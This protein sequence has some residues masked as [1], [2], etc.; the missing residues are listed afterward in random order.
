MQGLQIN[1]TVGRRFIIKM[2][3]EHKE[4]ME[5]KHEAVPGYKKIFYIILAIGSLYLAFIFLKSL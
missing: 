4:I 3:E 2:V 1:Q 5:L